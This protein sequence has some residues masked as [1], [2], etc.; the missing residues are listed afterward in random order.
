MITGMARG[1][2]TR[3]SLLPR[4]HADGPRRPPVR[5]GVEKSNPPD[6]HSRSALRSTAVF[7]RRGPGRL[8]RPVAASV[9]ESRRR[10]GPRSRPDLRPVRLRRSLRGGIV[11][12]IG[13]GRGP[14]SG[15][16]PA[17]RNGSSV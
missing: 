10:S 3:R 9:D 17:P 15:P 1:S 14:G 16:A 13:T 5:A 7:D 12:R 2:A 11:H 8:R 6:D 4:G